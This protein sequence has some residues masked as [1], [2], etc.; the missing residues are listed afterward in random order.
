M[1]VTL[2]FLDSLFMK[3]KLWCFIKKKRGKKNVFDNM[4]MLS[5]VL[6]VVK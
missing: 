1:L 4:C 6:S 3:G 5:H 2:R